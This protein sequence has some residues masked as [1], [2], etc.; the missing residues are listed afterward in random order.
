MGDE[1][2][3]SGHEY[4]P[5]PELLAPPAVPLTPLQQFVCTYVGRFDNLATHFVRFTEILVAN[6]RGCMVAVNSNFGHAAQ[7][8]YEYLIKQPKTRRQL[9]PVVSAS[10]SASGGG[11]GA[12]VASAASTGSASAG[13]AAGLKSSTRKLQGDGTCFNSAVEPVVKIGHPGLDPDK[14]YCVKS[15]PTTGEIQVPG[16]LALDLGDGRAV[17]EAFAAFL[18]SLPFDFSKPT[19]PPR[20]TTA[21]TATPAAEGAETATPAAET[22]TPAAETATPHRPITIRSQGPN[23]INFKFRLC[24]SSPRILVDHL[25]LTRYLCLLKASGAVAAP[26]APR[27][28]RSE[29]WE[30]VVVLPPFCVHEV[31]PPAEDVKVSFRFQGAAPGKKGPRVNVFQGGKVNILG[32]DSVDTAERVYAF[33]TELFALNWAHLVS[34]EPRRDAETAR[35]E[36][37]LQARAR[38]EAIA[39]AAA[40]EAAAAAAA[41]RLA[42]AVPA[43]LPDADFDAVW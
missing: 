14:I 7:P 27:N 32:A 42:H 10:G 31:K 16:V 3:V 15:F 17:L 2:F 40:A 21:E 8:G 24:R 38:A 12:S 22:A 26:G 19:A 29:R 41:A 4:L 20:L 37:Y 5:D 33:F 25:A 6:P 36:R 11:A 39:A 28:A 23:M 30:G 9:A 13:V 1:A 35:L 43:G 34:I 18:N